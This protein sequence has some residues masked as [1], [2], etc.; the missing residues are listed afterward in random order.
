MSDLPTYEFSDAGLKQALEALGGTGAEVASALRALG[1]KGERHYCGTCPVALYLL[2]VFPGA[3]GAEVHEEHCLVT[4]TVVDY[5]SVEAEAIRVET[6]LAVA[7]F[8]EDFDNGYYPQ[9]DSEV[10]HVDAA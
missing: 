4:R 5:V 8:A 6:P 9:L 2:R 10:S 1:I 7:C 3:D